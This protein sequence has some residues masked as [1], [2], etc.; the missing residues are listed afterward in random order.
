M[1]TRRLVHADLGPAAI[2]EA[3]RILRTGGTVAFPTETV[4]GLGALGLD[5]DALARIF[6]AKERPAED[7]LIL[8][9]GDPDWLSTLARDLPQVAETLARR[10]WPGPLT[11]VVPKADRVPD[12][13]TAGLP[14]VAVRMPA[15]PIA[16]ALV[17]A[18]GA[19]I[20]AP[21][22]NRFSRPSPT[23]A[24]HVLADLDGRIDAVI[25]GGPTELG[26]ESTVL[27]T[28]TEPP[29]I[30]RPGGVTRDDLV[31]VLGRP[32][33]APMLELDAA[34][35][36]ASPGQLT[37]HYSPK[38]TVRLFSSKTPAIPQRMIDAIRTSS[39]AGRVGVLAYAGDEIAL[40]DLPVMVE[41]L[42]PRD[43]PEI[44]ARR[45]YAALRTLDGSGVRVIFAR[46]ADP[47]G[48]GEALNDRLRRAASGRIEPG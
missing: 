11:L 10:F 4:Y 35:P 23:T 2:D 36:A 17:R 28:R 22:A 32:V 9:V 39:R 38:A 42:G 13:A 48:L 33:A 21:S 41:V 27:D 18:V 43:A 15:H 46:L 29:R 8:H 19:P 37:R 20:A 5:P 24:D 16:L 7:P 31:R 34:V 30:L 47:A 26:L 12:A 3:A 1:K 40:Q 45:L 44:L 14:S 6:V 25:D